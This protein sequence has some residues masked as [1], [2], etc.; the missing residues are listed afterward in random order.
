[1]DARNMTMDK[2]MMMY[3]VEFE[4]RNIY[5][6]YKQNFIHQGI[7]DQGDNVSNAWTISQE[8]KKIG[9]PTLIRSITLL[10]DM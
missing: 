7:E 1:M 3:Y 8:K 6:I 10:V 2:M 4:I 5:L 9:C